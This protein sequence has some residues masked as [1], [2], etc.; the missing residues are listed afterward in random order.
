MPSLGDFLGWGLQGT[1]RAIWFAPY[2]VNQRLLSGPRTMNQR[3][4]SGPVTIDV[5]LALAVVI[6]YLRCVPT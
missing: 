5:A 3:F 1:T 4:P 6:G 2:S